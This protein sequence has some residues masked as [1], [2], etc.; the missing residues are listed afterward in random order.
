M[1]SASEAYI[2]TSEIREKNILQ[3]IQKAVDSGRFSTTF[4][5]TDV[6]NDM[7]QCLKNQGYEIENT[8]DGQTTVSWNKPNTKIN[9]QL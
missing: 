7:R 1:L 9:Y 5:K 6:D 3:Q 8:S 4:W 2:K